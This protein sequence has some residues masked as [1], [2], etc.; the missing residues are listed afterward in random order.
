MGPTCPIIRIAHF[1]GIL[2]FKCQD[3][4]FHG[5]EGAE[6][7]VVNTAVD[8]QGNCKQSNQK[9]TGTDFYSSNIYYSTSIIIVPRDIKSGRK[10]TANSIPMKSI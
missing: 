8:R 9:A 6:G 3:C 2:F 1:C 7:V 4:S 5:T 10:I